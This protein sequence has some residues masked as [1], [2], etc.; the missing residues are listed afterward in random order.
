MCDLCGQVTKYKK[1]HMASI[2]KVYIGDKYP[3][4]I[5]DKVFYEKC[6]LKKH[7]RTHIAG[8]KYIW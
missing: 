7:Q 5:C 4:D 2:H 1:R 6:E 8:K 3:C